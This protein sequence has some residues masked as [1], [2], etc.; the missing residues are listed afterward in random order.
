MW[1]SAPCAAVLPGGGGAPL[2]WQGGSGPTFPS[3][4]P[5]LRGGGRWGGRAGM[6]QSL[7]PPSAPRFYSPAAAGHRSKAKA[8]APPSGYIPQRRPSRA[9]PA[10]RLTSGAT[11]PGR[12]LLPCDVRLAGEWGGFAVGGPC[13]PFSAT[14]P[15]VRCP[16]APGAARGVSCCLVSLCCRVH[17]VRV[18]CIAGG[19]I[20]SPLPRGQTCG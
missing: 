7:C 2:A 5:A 14:C 20:R 3:Q 11:A 1:R 17:T 9:A 12:L 10:R 6:V 19:P 16:W 18:L 15:A 8:Q 13:A 4:L